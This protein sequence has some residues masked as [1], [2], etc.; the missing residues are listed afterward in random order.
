MLIVSQVQ[1]PSSFRSKDP[2]PLFAQFLQFPTLSSTSEESALSSEL[3]IS[4]DPA[5]VPGE[6][7]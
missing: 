7:A 4:E 6:V 5:G 3:G 2:L 1:N